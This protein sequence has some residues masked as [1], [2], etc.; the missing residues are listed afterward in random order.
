MLKK[1]ICISWKQERMLNKCWKRLVCGVFSFVSNII[2]I[3]FFLFFRFR[4]L[5][6]CASFVRFLARHTQTLSRQPRITQENRI[7][8]KSNNNAR[9]GHKIVSSKLL[10]RSDSHTLTH[11]LAVLFVCNA[12][13]NL[14]YFDFNNSIMV[15]FG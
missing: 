3:W 4:M 12:S 10:I 6:G 9:Y 7:E 5:C 13:D 15:H 1:C 11:S 14:L 2:E 8:R